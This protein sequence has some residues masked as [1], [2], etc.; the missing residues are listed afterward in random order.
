MQ[1]ETSKLW[2][3]CQKRLVSPL[4][5]IA[6]VTK[7]RARGTDKC[8]RSGA[9]QVTESTGETFPVTL[10]QRG[11][12]SEKKSIE[13]I[14]VEG[15]GALGVLSHAAACHADWRLFLWW[16]H[17]AAVSNSSALCS[18]VIQ[19]ILASSHLLFSYLLVSESWHVLARLARKDNTWKR[20]QRGFS[21]WAHKWMFLEW[22]DVP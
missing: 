20:W 10:F 3:S 4:L 8:P 11:M 14:F 12:W 18:P 17:K 21:S 2:E 6:S 5:G 19:E 1:A 13:T 15:K 9:E 16:E 22:Q 7:G